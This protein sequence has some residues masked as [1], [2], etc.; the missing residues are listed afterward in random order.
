MSGC[1]P[2]GCA[3]KKSTPTDRKS[4]E[5]ELVKDAIRAS[6]CLETAYNQK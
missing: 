1:R 3:V 2:W 6:D 4:V 5:T